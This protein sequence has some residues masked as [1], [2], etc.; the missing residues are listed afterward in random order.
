MLIN[1]IK[2]A[3]LLSTLIFNIPSNAMT[4]D[5]IHVIDGDTIKTKIADVPEPFDII[6]I[7]IRGIDT[8]EIR[9]I[10]CKKQ[11]VIA[12]QAKLFVIDKIKNNNNK[13]TLENI[14]VG[15]FGGRYVADV[16]TNNKNLGNQLIEHG[17]AQPWNGTGKKP[18]WCE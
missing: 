15:K 5:V 17:L 1:K 16:F 3:V 7:R 2:Y 18:I 8:P 10:K 12:Y 11:K 13:I 4:V 6:S 14:K 9:G